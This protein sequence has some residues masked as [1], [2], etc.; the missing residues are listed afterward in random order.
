M[1]DSI[2]EEAKQ[3]YSISEQIRMAEQEES[4]AIRRGNELEKNRAKNKQII[5]K[6]KLEHYKNVAQVVLTAGKMPSEDK[7][8]IIVGGQSGAGKS[9]LVRLAQSELMQNG[10]IV[11][12]DELRSY[13]PEYENASSE[14]PE[15]THAVLHEDT[16]YVKNEVLEELISQEYDVIYEG[17]LRN[18][19]G[20]LD[21]AQKFRDN[22]YNIDMMLM[23]VPALESYGSTFV[24][25]AIALQTNKTP[26]WVEKYAHDG[27]YEGVLR[28]VQAFK[29]QNLVDNIGV[30]VRSKDEPEKI[31]ETQEHQFSDAI[32]AIKTGREAGRKQAVED[33][34]EKYNVVTTILQS[35]RP[36]MIEKLS[37]WEQ[38]YKDEK[39]ELIEKDQTGITF[40]ED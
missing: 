34:Q 37:D 22:D 18:T 12:F 25:Y 29:E 38:L 6:K 30:Y 8:L 7:T 32:E 24:R 15:I 10:V 13:H 39:Q 26:R 16:E 11:D 9:R 3:K 14:Y 35:K 33:Y 19:Q 27:S 5:L 20:F 28:T 1:E 23:A 40:N 2:L 21:F 17:A 31:Y 4:E 36:E